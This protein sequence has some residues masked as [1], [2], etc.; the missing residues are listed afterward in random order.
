MKMLFI[1][2]EFLFIFPLVIALPTQETVIEEV[3]KN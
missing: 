1:E 2:F 3:Q